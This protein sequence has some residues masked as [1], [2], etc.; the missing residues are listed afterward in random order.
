[1]ALCIPFPEP[2]CLEK[3]RK[4]TAKIASKVARGRNAEGYVVLLYYKR[5]ASLG[6]KVHCSGYLV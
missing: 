5:R 6:A 4:S 2:R 3:L 1:M